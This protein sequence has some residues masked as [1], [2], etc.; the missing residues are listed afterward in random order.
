MLS[1]GP[2][3]IDGGRV[4]YRQNTSMSTHRTPS[5]RNVYSMEVT[6]Y[7]V[8]HN[9]ICITGLFNSSQVLADEEPFHGARRF[10]PG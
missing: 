6:I 1:V 9:A 8:N 3:M 4:I 5:Q 10:W 2:D 7:G